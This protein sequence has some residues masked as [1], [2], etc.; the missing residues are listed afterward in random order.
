[1]VH[2]KCSKSLT[3]FWLM[4]PFVGL[5]QAKFLPAVLHTSR[6]TPLL[7]LLKIS[8]LLDEWGKE[9]N[10]QICTYLYIMILSSVDILDVQLLPSL[11]YM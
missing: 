2:N 11:H 6:E 8:T 10:D 7:S 3:P 5:G 1:M 4:L 9:K